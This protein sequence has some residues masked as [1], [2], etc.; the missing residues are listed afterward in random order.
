MK[1]RITAQDLQLIQ[2][3]LQ[4]P[5]SIG[6]LELPA[7]QAPYPAFGICFSNKEQV[8]E[9]GLFSGLSIL[10][11]MPAVLPLGHQ[12]SHFSY[13]CNPDGSIRWIFP[14]GSRSASF[15][16]TYSTSSL[17]GK[18][19]AKSIEWAFRLRLSALVV[20]GSFTVVHQEALAIDRLTKGY[21]SYGIFTGTPGPNRKAVLAAEKAGTVPC[22]FK[23]GL[24]PKAVQLLGQESKTLHRLHHLQIEN[25]TVPTVRWREAGVLGLESVKTKGTKSRGTLSGPHFTAWA[26]WTQQT[27]AAHPL[28][29]SDA[30]QLAMD[31][32]S[33]LERAANPLGGRPMIQQLR[34]LADSFSGEDLHL[35]SLSHGDF[36]PWNCF[37]S[38]DGLQ[39]YDWELSQRDAPVLFDLF[40]FIFQAGVLLH[41]SDFESIKTQVDQLLSQPSVQ[42]MVAQYRI[43]VDLHYR[44]FLF[45][46]LA[47]Y[48]W[49]YTQQEELHQQV[50]WLMRV[51]QA[52]LRDALPTVAQAPLR[53]ALIQD[54]FSELQGS[55]YALMKHIS[56][57]VHALSAHSDL[58]ILVLPASIASTL[59][60][61]ETHSSVSKMQVKRLSYLTQVGIY[62][63]DGAFLQL[64]LLT[65]FKR[66]HL[67]MIPADR[68]LKTAEVN[69]EGIRVACPLCNFLYCYLFYQL[70]GSDLPEHYQQY[71][72]NLPVE[73]RNRIHQFMDRRYRQITLSL[74]SYFAYS[75]AQKQYECQLLRQSA[76]NS[77]IQGLLH[78]LRYLLDLVRQLKGSTGQTITFTGVDGVGKSTMI[79]DLQ[80]ELEKRFRQ[81][82]VLLRHRP[83]LLPI[84][85]SYRYGKKAAEQKAANTLPRQGGNQSKIGSLLR[86]A[87]YF[88]DYLIG[89]FYVWLRYN[90]WGT[91]V[92]FDRYYFDFINDARR[93]NL[94]LNRKMVRSLYRFLREPEVN[95]L[96]TAPTPVIYQRKQEL[97]P[98]EISLLNQGYRQLFS[99]LA[100]RKVKAAYH[101]FR[102][103]DR[104]Q[105]LQQIMQ[106]IQKAA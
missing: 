32:L 23:I 51:W 92:I 31:R 101:H 9:A 8:P 39:A 60:F 29:A 64:D 49:V 1:T 20:S 27:L 28:K 77:G 87:Y 40:H 46:H 76:M 21:S 5:G 7:P 106:V 71:F 102:N 55:D 41:R 75:P 84:L 58:D 15:L 105:T 74:A 10:G 34:Q 22:F 94:V 35:T 93:S 30:Y 89:Q 14:A 82:V 70:N 19:I 4:A 18:I 69:A 36:T 54:L 72:L 6:Q 98:K 83:S 66:K 2:D 59:Q 103:I 43:D 45:Q 67:E 37:V 100:N 57:P 61:L 90:L 78:H 65:R 50:N 88:S 26:N 81:K 68:V 73:K 85:S 97:R 11:E 24:T 63:K 3:L 17:R 48:L 96:L 86:F 56:G 13:I 62:L 16:K 52:A 44:L 12:I 33:L 38:K 91:T 47:H 42:A 80:H 25:L 99:E 104:Q 95:I 53:P 79:N